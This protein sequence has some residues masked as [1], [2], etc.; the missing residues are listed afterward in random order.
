MAQRKC[1]H[2]GHWN[3]DLDYCER[4]NHVISLY[5]QSKNERKEKLKKSIA[6]EPDSL[7]KLHDKLINS[8]FL[9]VRGFYLVL[10]S[11]WVMLVA[12]ISFFIYA[13]AWAPG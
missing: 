2:C 6:K 4:C 3:T 12:F 8:K 9:V 5:L 10:R 7:D 13:I 1:G 11:V